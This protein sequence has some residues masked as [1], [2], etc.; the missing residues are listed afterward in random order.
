VRRDRKGMTVRSNRDREV[1]PASTHR[2]L[3]AQLLLWTGILV[4]ISV[5]YFQ[6]QKPE[7]NALSQFDLTRALVEHGTFSID[8]YHT[9][10]IDKAFFGGRYYCDKS[11]VNAFLGVPF[12]AL[13]RW[14][15]LRSDQ[16]FDENRARYW[17][18]CAVEGTAA[19]LLAMMVAASLRRRGVPSRF[20]AVGGALWIVATPLLGYA[21][22]FYNYLPACAMLLAGCLLVEPEWTRPGTLS[23]ARI[24]TAGLLLGLASWTL[25]T[26]VIA[27]L[28]MTLP[29]LAGGRAVNTG[30]TANWR[31]WCR[32]WPWMLGGIV[33]A[34]GYFAYNAYVFGSFSSPYV[35]EAKPLFRQEMS[36]GI[37][38]ATWPR[39]FVA[40]LLTG[41]KFQGLFLWFPVTTLAAMG[42]L[43]RLC[44]AR[45]E[46]PESRGARIESLVALMIFTGLLAYTSGYYMWWGGYAY[47]PRHLIPALPLLAL[48]MVPW[49]REGRRLAAAL[50]LC[51]ALGST[52]F[53]VTAVA[54]NP[55]PWP[56]LSNEQLMAPHSVAQWPSPYLNLQFTFW[57]LAAP[58]KNW[59][60]TLGL[61]GRATLLPLAAIWAIAGL[62]L[63][64]FGGQHENR[65]THG[66]T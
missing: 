38:G 26:L 63:L 1:P 47:A 60:H 46:S 64:L 44:S 52:L 40:W 24:C 22:H 41:H 27:A 39:P 10:T 65:R 45:E 58:D 57:S 25:N 48:G 6:N 8:A 12:F 43:W 14:W 62:M 33:G 15:A 50:F 32:L 28:T 23:P 16:T 29:L 21:I 54:V 18:T 36:K 42:T 49:L 20:S 2:P 7:A 53:N 31:L 30:V 59:G 3:R 51:V 37:M 19:A 55:Q 61:R 17:T 5:A 4:F 56:G 11:P 9:N 35:Y 66:S 13:Y 34:A